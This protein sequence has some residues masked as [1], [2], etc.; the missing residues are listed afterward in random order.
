M[1]TST[2]LCMDRTGDVT[3]YNANDSKYDL[4]KRYLSIEYRMATEK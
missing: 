3:L 1:F 2:G 4:I